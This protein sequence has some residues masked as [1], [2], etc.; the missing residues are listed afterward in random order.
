MPHDLGLDD[1]APFARPLLGGIPRLAVQM[2]RL[3]R[4]A[5]AHPRPAHQP[6]RA[7]LQARV[8]RHAHDVLDLLAFQEGED[9]G[10]G[11]APIQ[12]HPKRGGREGGPEFA[13]QGPQDA[14]RPQTSR[15][16]AGAPATANCAGSS[17]N[18][19]VATTGR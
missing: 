16:R 4:L 19:T 9:L 18:V 14:S 2:R 7:L 15:R 10:A 3:P 6:P 13:Q 1:D 11:K 8:A 17:L 5:R 12:A